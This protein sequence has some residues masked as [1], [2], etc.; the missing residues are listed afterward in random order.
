MQFLISKIEKGGMKPNQELITIVKSTYNPET[1]SKNYIQK[2]KE[3]V[4]K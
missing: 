4:S 2:L 1:L 3:I